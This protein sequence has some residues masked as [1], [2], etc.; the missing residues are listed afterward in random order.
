MEPVVSHLQESRDIAV[1]EQ[2]EAP[3]ADHWSKMR[4]LRGQV[5][6][7]RLAD[8]EIAVTWA[9]AGDQHA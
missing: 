4:R 6:E 3:L 8:A 7:S 5:D 2:D 9:P 1:P